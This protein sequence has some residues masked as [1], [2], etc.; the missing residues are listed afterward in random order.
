MK[1]RKGSD[2]WVYCYV[3]HAFKENG[4]FLKL[5][6]G[7][8]EDLGLVAVQ[9]NMSGKGFGKKLRNSDVAVLWLSEKDTA[10]ASQG[11]E[12]EY[13]WY[14]CTAQQWLAYLEHSVFR[15]VTY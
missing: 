1:T 8:E 15:V 6:E 12:G 7:E 3:V 5:P 2:S 9:Y 14:P 13:A 4:V 10:S 11:W